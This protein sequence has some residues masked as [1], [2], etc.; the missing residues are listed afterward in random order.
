MAPRKT[1]LTL[2]RFNPSSTRGASEVL[3]IS[4][5][6]INLAIFALALWATYEA[7][8]ANYFTNQNIGSKTFS[9]VLVVNA[10]LALI[11]LSG[12]SIFYAREGGLLI[13][14]ATLFPI[15]VTFF[16]IVYLLNVWKVN[17]VIVEKE[18]DSA[19]TFI[20]VWSIVVLVGSVFNLTLNYNRKK[21]IDKL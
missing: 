8:Q 19:L 9:V 11:A 7:F 1:N 21:R 17:G 10:S 5:S 18:T 15:A 6:G 2:E 4:L 20:K 3:D 16:H 14:L 13:L 12:L